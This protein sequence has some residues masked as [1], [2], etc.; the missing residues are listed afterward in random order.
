EYGLTAREGRANNTVDENGIRQVAGCLP[1]DPINHRF[2]L[3]TSTSDK[4]VWV[5]PKGGWE[6][7]ETVRQAAMRETWEEAGVKGPLTRHI[8]TFVEKAREGGIRAHHWI[9]EME[10]REVAQ[11]FP[12]E[13]KRERRW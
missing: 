8:G 13:H 9:Y 5:I 11:R 2:L 4:N 6:Q 10:I 3:I 1:I 12:E 7:D